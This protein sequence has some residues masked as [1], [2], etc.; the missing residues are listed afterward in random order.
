MRCVLRIPFPG[1]RPRTED[2][3]RVSA[4]ADDDPSAAVQS[5]LRAVAGDPRPHELAGF[6]EPL[7]HYR[8]AFPMSRPSVLK[9]WR[10]RMLSPIGASIA[11]LALALGGTAAAAY[12]GALPTPAQ[13][14]AHTV[15]GAPAAHPAATTSPSATGS[16]SE[17]PSATATATEGTSTKGP[18][19]PDA[20]GPAMFGLC[21]AWTAH[22]ANGETANGKA[23]DAVAFK[24][25]AAAAG[26]ADKIA[27]Y[28]ATILKSPSP[29]VV[30]GQPTAQQTSESTSHPTG[31]PSSL[32]IQ[33][34]TDHP[35][36]KPAL[37]TK[38]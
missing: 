7:A 9:T 8:A 12:T 31:K 5:L 1:E 4:M 25:L 29:T 37:P 32:P 6:R 18:V 2:T 13:D 34:R 22:Q 26:G 35:T 27:A 16:A 21:T 17:T 23:D 33:A 11:G 14:F 38:A 30:P 36:G 19:G 10:T 15:I 28:C 3:A 24:N 20:S